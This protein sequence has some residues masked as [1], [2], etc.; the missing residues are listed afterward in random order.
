MDLG[1]NG[2]VA[3]VL[4]G[5]GGL[6]G[7]I[8]RTLAAE[9][10]RVVVADLVEAAATST[11]T[12]IR[13]AGGEARSSSWDLADLSAM[14]R[15]VDGLESDG[16]QVDILVNITGGPPPSP[17][18]DQSE[19]LWEEHFK[20][21]VLP[22]IKLTDRLLPGMKE[23]G[24]GRIITSTSSGVVVPIPNLGLSNA[25]RSTLLGWS[26]TLAREV[27]AHGVTSNVIIPGRIATKRITFLDEKKA[28]REGRAVQ[29]V[30]DESVSS[31]PVGR[32]G[33][34]AEYAAAV[35][36]LAS[37]QASY[38]TGTMIRVDGGL[39]PSV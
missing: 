11:V 32:Y 34:P 8:A 24:W 14:E 3:L 21:M 36:F 27:G 37:A 33:E 2:R 26:K 39:I 4:G 17:V 5:G 13:E 38:V 12:D 25:L 20:S 9:G 19:D 28:E 23:R 7:A 10:A 29:D 16:W 1:I 35:A 31:I 30:A 22:V 18:T 6:G 15:A